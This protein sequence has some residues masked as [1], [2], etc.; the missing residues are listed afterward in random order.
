M[1]ELLLD[2]CPAAIRYGIQI[3]RFWSMSYDEIM[4][5]IGAKIEE[6]KDALKA[7]ILRNS[8]L[9]G[10][11]GLAINDPR[12][13]PRDIRRVYPE[14]FREEKGAE[15]WKKNKAEMA[16]YAAAHNAKV[17]AGDN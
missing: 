11:I 16:A 15:D 3:E 12:K 6:E 8:E 7:Q 10:L 13:L 2:V 9:A 1:T 5:T 14:L 17:K 4:L